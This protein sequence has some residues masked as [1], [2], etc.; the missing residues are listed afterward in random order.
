[1][2]IVLEPIPNADSYMQRQQSIHNE[3]REVQVESFG[4]HKS[5]P[6]QERV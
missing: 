6:G 4:G 5:Q 1:M 2:I 3:I